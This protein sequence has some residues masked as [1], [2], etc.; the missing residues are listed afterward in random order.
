MGTNIEK[1]V[2][3]CGETNWEVQCFV[4]FIFFE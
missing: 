2:G 1:F 3:E 4:A